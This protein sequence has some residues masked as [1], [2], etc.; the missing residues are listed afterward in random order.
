MSGNRF[1]EP[2]N[3]FFL[4]AG[5]LPLVLAVSM[6]VAAICLSLIFLAYYHR[7]SFLNSEIGTK[8]NR[9]SRS[10]INYLLANSADIPFN[11]TYN[12]DLFGDGEDS[13]SLILK[14]WGI[15]KLGVASSYLGGRSRQSAALFGSVLSK[16]ED[17]ALNLSDEQSPLSI[18]GSTTIVGNCYLPKAGIRTATIEGKSFEGEK[19]VDGK[20]F[21]SST[22]FPEYEINMVNKLLDLLEGKQQNFY[23]LESID[24]L[25]DSL[26][27]SFS[28]EY[29][30]YYFTSNT[31]TL[32]QKLA[33]K[34]V[35]HSA[36]EVLVTA[37][38]EIEEVIILA[39]KIT[40]KSGFQGKLQ[41]FATDTII[42]ENEAKLLYPS[43]IGIMGDFPQP[44]IEIQEDSRVEGTLFLL[45]N[46]LEYKQRLLRIS[47][48]AS[49]VGKVYAD[50]FVELSG[51]IIGGVTCRKF[52]L[53][54]A[55]TVYENHLLNAQINNIRLPESYLN[56]FFFYKNKNAAI[57]KWV[58]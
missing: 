51:E 16:N 55:S 17:V 37:A 41:L 32:S 29:T 54:T 2:K 28:D 33:G 44:F 6:I 43:C 5:V 8:L 47:S 3:K 31:I 58:N 39:P 38:S 18:A 13:V 4:E 10:G 35:V 12:L 34:L 14:P 30:N 25:D 22:G 56:G 50:A 26:S 57:L 20:V 11:E 53:Q 42:V 23:I 36:T 48:G 45:G 21:V 7:I 46:S 9:N 15:F 19:L 40:I 27:K 52:L 1:F 24:Y 49:V